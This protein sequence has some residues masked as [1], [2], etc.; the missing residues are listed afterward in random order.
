MTVLII[1]T[2]PDIRYLIREF[3]RRDLN[4]EPCVAASFAEA[5]R[6]LAD[7]VFDVV[8]IG[9]LVSVAPRVAAG[10]VKALLPEAAVLIFSP[11]VDADDPAPPGVGM[12]A[13]PQFRQLSQKI[14]ELTGLKTGG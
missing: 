9:S 8:V 10:K 1:E 13:Q 11:N 2:N 12:V 4:V 5:S 7:S 3:L 14:G 6:I